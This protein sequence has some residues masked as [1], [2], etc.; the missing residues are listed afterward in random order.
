M[1]HVV[2][3][4]YKSGYSLKSCILLWNFNLHV[5]NLIHVPFALKCLSKKVFHGWR[6]YLWQMLYFVF[7]IIQT[8]AYF[9]SNRL[10]WVDFYIYDLLERSMDFGLFNFGSSSVIQKDVLVD[11]P[12]LG[13]FYR[14]IS[15]RPKIVKYRLSD[16]RFPYVIA[17]KPTDL[18]PGK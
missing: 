6:Y 3:E 14:Q 15:S 8:D 18:A 5:K 1:V 17:N 11:F 12:K 2:I 9:A 7:S 4:L 16:R 13:N 10:T